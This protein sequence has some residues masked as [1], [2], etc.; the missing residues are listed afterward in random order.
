MNQIIVLRDL[1]PAMANVGRCVMDRLHSAQLKDWSVISKICKLVKMIIHGNV[2][3][4]QEK[5]DSELDQSRNRFYFGIS[6]L[7]RVRLSRME[8]RGRSGRVHS[9]HKEWEAE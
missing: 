6:T 2:L 8:Q 3:V 1:S 5:F 9:T 7:Q 4:L